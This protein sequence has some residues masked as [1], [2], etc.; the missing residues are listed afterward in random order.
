LEHGVVKLCAESIFNRFQI[1]FVPVCGQLHPLSQSALEIVDK[2]IIRTAVASVNVATRHKF[3]L[4]VQSRP[5]PNIAPSAAN[6]FDR[7]DLLLF[8][9]DERPNFIVLNPGES[10][11]TESSV[12]IRG[13]CCANLNQQFLNR[14]AVNTGRA[15]P[16]REANCPQPD[17]RQHGLFSRCSIC[18][19]A[20][21]V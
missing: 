9:A 16:W 10:D 17:K 1:R 2:V 15:N 14:R 5:R 20:Q 13:T 8:A 6:V 21:Y 7:A 11:I 4:R 19:W 3:G 18:S 12:W